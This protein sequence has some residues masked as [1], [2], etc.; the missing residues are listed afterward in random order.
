M[1][2]D[3]ISFYNPKDLGCFDIGITQINKILPFTSVQGVFTTSAKVEFFQGSRLV[4][5]VEYADMVL[6]GTNT[7]GQSK[8]LSLTLNG[9]DF[10]DYKG[11][12]LEAVCSSFFTV[13][14]IEM[15]FT[16]EIK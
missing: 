15:T 16:L 1:S 13:G 7:Q 14:D 8:T 4:R 5:T 9:A 10:E 11:A 12:G 2:K 6:S 3:N